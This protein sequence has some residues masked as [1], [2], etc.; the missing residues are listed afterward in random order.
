MRQRLW[1]LAVLLAASVAPLTAQQGYTRFFPPEE[2]AARR[3]K[4]MEHIGDA[5]AIMQGTTE[6]AGEEPLRQSNQFFYLTGVVEPRAFLIVDGRTKKTTL[7]LQ[8]YNTGRANRNYGPYLGPGD[9]AAKVTG[10]DF[11]VVRD[12]FASAVAKLAA[13]G[14][15]ILTPYRAEVQG[16]ESADDPGGLNR[17]NK[18]DPW[19]R[20]YLAR[21]SVPRASQGCCAEI[22]D[23]ESRSAHRFVA[24]LQDSA[25]DRRDS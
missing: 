23:Q 3:A 14:R 8:P 2:F 11:V 9:E 5:V 22:R 6:R 18:A 19:G 7:F 25:R 15:S 24:R 21:R 4:I 16:S 10:I 20:P 17:R 12:S 13:E 1:G